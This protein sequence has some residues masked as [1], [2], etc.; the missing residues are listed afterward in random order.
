[1]NPV[2]SSVPNNFCPS[3]RIVT[4]NGS[5]SSGASRV[6]SSKHSM[7]LSY[8]E[9]VF[10]KPG[11]KYIKMRRPISNKSNNT[12]NIYFLGCFWFKVQ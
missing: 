1:M 3:N 9:Q 2:R 10:A 4:C 7:A 6:V 12:L 11:I 8:Y 5:F